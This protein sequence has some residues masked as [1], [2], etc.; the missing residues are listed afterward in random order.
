MVFDFCIIG[1]QQ[2]Y[3]ER[4]CSVRMYRENGTMQKKS[5]VEI[6]TRRQVGRYDAIVFGASVGGVRAAIGLAKENRKVLLTEETDW[7]GGQLTAQGVPPDENRFIEEK[8][9]T[10]SYR[11]FRKK[12]RDYY[13]SLPDVTQ[14]A[15]ADMFLNPGKAWVCR[16]SFEPKVALR[17]LEEEM[18]PYLEGG[19]IDLRKNTI[20]LE[21]TAE[22]DLVT[23]AVIADL[24]TGSREYVT[25]PYF[26]DATDCGDFLPIA[27]VEYRMGREAGSE[28]GE[29]GAAETAD[30]QDMQPA[31]WVVALE[32]REKLAEEDRMKKPA[33]YDYFSSLGVTYGDDPLFSWYIPTLDGKGKRKFRMFNEDPEKG[34]AGLWEYRRV[35]AK[36]IFCKPTTEIS[37]INW[38]QQ[39]YSFGNVFGNDLAGY[40]RHM[41]KQLALCLAYWIQNEA[42]TETGGKGYPVRLSKETF[43]TEDGCAKAPYIRES[44]RIVALRTVTE[45]DVSADKNAG[46]KFFEDSVGVGH[47][48]IDFHFTTKSG[49][50]FNRATVP[51][52][53]P[54]SALIPVRV[55]NVL[56]GC[57]NIGVTHITNGCYRLHP[58]EWNI[59]ESV[60]LLVAYCLENGCLPRE[61]TGK[62]LREYQGRLKQNGVQLHWD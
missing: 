56:P 16:L 10:E 29:E 6:E 1:A 26:I 58:I 34:L 48:S 37:L 42:P 35:R 36:E 27:G 51:F 21:C 24:R 55:K 41:A 14:E 7:I 30:E 53:I 2:D 3:N 39:D 59:G 45:G 44:R 23:G 60:G 22:A 13:R 50:T 62:R 54:L 52:E 40:H 19:Q 4:N 20:V 49:E 61:V 17:L 38:P 32:L 46:P 43:D 8:G 12:I 15:K 57:K 11:F 9:C 47:Y 18:R 33:E 25:A 5:K 31:T 28:T